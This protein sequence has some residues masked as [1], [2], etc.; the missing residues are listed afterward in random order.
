M[1]KILLHIAGALVILL[2]ALVL[3]V[4]SGKPSYKRDGSKRVLTSLP[5]Q[6]YVFGMAIKKSMFAKKTKSVEMPDLS[7]VQ[8][9]VTVS[10]EHVA[11]YR[12]IC[13]FDVKGTAAPVTYPYLL[14]FPIQ[15][16][17]LVDKAFPFQAMGL[18][19]LANRIK[20]FGAIKVGSTVAVS[21]KF[22]KAVVPHAKG[23]C[24]NVISEIF[25]TDGALLWRCDSTYLSRARST[26]LATGDTYASKISESDVAGLTQQKD[27]TLAG[28]FS[29][30][31]A[32]ISGD[33]NPIHLYAVTAKLFGF[34]HGCIMHGM[35]SVA[36]SAAAL[37]PD[38]TTPASSTVA[39]EI[40]AEMKLPMYLPNKPS[41]LQK[42]VAPAQAP[43]KT[44]CRNARVF[45][46]D[47]NMRKEKGPVP[48][49]KGWCAW[50]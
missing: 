29:R 11:Q 13:G 34:P 45:E 20:Q 40:Y 44:Q 24:F 6:A 15:G 47:M 8:S 43:E 28:D 5:S 26:S 7:F 12:D 48:H 46:L 37:M 42:E 32:S 36:A 25:S 31:Y 23:Y 14:I 50:N 27:W 1:L 9:G 39:A 4:M 17:L 3:W 41:L 22:D 30:K 21:A 33:Y 10:S 2:A 49:L 18:V 19:H 35:W 38:V 16:L